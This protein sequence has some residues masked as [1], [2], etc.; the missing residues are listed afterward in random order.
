MWNSINDKY[1]YIIK[2]KVDKKKLNNLIQIQPK[3]HIVTNSSNFKQL[4]NQL[5][6]KQTLKQTLKK[7]KKKQKKAK[8]S[9]K[10]QKKSKK[11]AKKKAK[12]HGLHK[13]K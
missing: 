8:K 12:K 4:T 13:G 3:Q 11:K 7:A 5:N 6:Y 9:K 2:K 10:K 1:T